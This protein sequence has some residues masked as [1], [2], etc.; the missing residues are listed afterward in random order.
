VAMA[1]RTRAATTAT[2]TTPTT[3]AA[4]IQSTTRWRECP[5][6]RATLS[7]EPETTRDYPKEQPEEMVRGHQGARVPWRGGEMIC[8]APGIGC[9]CSSCGRTPAWTDATRS[10]CRCR[11]RRAPSD[12]TWPLIELSPSAHL[13][14]LAGGPT[15]GLLAVEHLVGAATA[16]STSAHSHALLTPL[17]SVL[18]IAG[19]ARS[20]RARASRR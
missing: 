17:G 15:R 10:S 20:G 11:V 12:R 19:T 13:I 9:R 6:P 16:G 1:I 18:G 5:R 8:M 2:A 14:E 7:L 4:I 3:R